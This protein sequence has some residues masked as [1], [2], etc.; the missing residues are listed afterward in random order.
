MRATT[1]S[2]PSFRRSLRLPLGA[3]LLTALT[4]ACWHT[5]APTD[6]T[7][8]AGVGGSA[9]TGTGAGG[10][11]GGMLVSGAGTGASPSAGGSKASGGTGATAGAPGTGG[12]GPAS[13]GAGGSTGGSGGMSMSGGAGMGAAGAPQPMVMCMGELENTAL[14]S[15]QATA[16]VDSANVKGD[17]PHFWDTFGTGELPLFFHTADNW[18]DTLKAH[19]VDGVKNLGVKRLR[20]H[21]LFHDDVGIYHEDSSGNPIYDFTKSDQ[22][23]DFFKEQGIE[24]IVELAPMPHDLAADP[25]KTVFDWNMIVSVPK[26]YA[27]WQELVTKFVQHSIDR[28]GLDTVNNWYF[29]VWNEPECCNNKFWSG[30]LDDYFKLYD[31]TAAGVRAALPTG[32]VGGPVSSQPVELTGNSMV[33]QQFLQHVTTDNYV[34]P[35][36]PGVLDYFSFHAWSFLSGSIDGYFTGLDLL[37]SFNKKDTRIA[38]TEYG[39][40]YEFGLDDEPQEMDQGAAFAVQTYSDIV[41]RCTK[42]NRRLPIAYS[43]WVISDIFDESKYRENDPFIGCMG[44]TSRQNIH[45]PVYNAY[46]FLT[47]LGNQQV[48]LD[49][50]GQ[51]GVG[52][53]A[54]RSAD[55]GV[56]LILYNGQNPGVGPKTET[57]YQNADAISIGVSVSGLDPKFPFDVT[58]WHVDHT[59]GN[60]YTVWQNKGRPNM[61]AMTDA[62]WQDLRNVMDSPAEPLGKAVCGSTFT[63]TFQLSSPGVLFVK[64]A[65][66]SP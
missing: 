16:T 29:E 65:P 62:D 54:T 44:L 42:D 6:D 64:L 25:S 58:A 28:Y 14:S 52:G 3:A 63:H 51:A 4:P 34:T 32:R 2:L 55:G 24:P 26:D 60:A 18:A 8:G 40:T 12:A 46:R 27:R 59:A 38:I 20:Q 5:A 10:G 11:S 36:Q 17:L 23:F 45:K 30:T 33:G 49:V 21:G 15:P 56:E 61:T 35:G 22:I 9:G 13:G 43:W 47:Q 57:Y 37:D 7:P 31:Y 41:Q 48:S 19:I 1:P 39:P 66:A 53:M 50:T